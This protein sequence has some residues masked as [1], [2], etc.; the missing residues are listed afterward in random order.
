MSIVANISRMELLKF[1][2]IFVFMFPDAYGVKLMSEK[3]MKHHK[4]HHHS[5][6]HADKPLLSL[7]E[8][9]AQSREL[10]KAFQHN[11]EVLREKVKQ[12]EE[13]DAESQPAS[14]IEKKPEKPVGLQA[15]EA[16]TDQIM[17]FTDRMRKMGN[18]AALF[19]G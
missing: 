17:A 13:S 9:L 5:E 15:M 6:E 14:F 7:S 2:L 8:L 19:S 3:R 1:F 4:T 18:D 11:A 12:T 10:T 16:V